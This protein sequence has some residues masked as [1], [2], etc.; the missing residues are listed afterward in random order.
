MTHSFLRSALF[1]ST[2]RDFPSSSSLLPNVVLVYEKSPLWIYMPFSTHTPSSTL[3]FLLFS[4]FSLQRWFHICGLGKQVLPNIYTGH[5]SAAESE[6]HRNHPIPPAEAAAFRTLNQFPV[7]LGLC[8][9]GPSSATG[10][11]GAL[12]LS[13]SV[14]I[15]VSP[16]WTLEQHKTEMS[17]VSS[18]SPLR[19]Q[20]A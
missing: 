9:L 17:L 12:N 16:E 11:R 3:F 4:L 20:L 13:A 7:V 18:E 10:Q 8:P 6:K 14:N 15:P 19:S 5:I 2:V 1:I